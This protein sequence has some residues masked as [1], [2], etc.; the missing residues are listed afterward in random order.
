MR[1][2]RV[3]LR[4]HPFFEG[5]R[6]VALRQQNQSY[7]TWSFE[8]GVLLQSPK[9]GTRHSH[10]ENGAM[11]IRMWRSCIVLFVLLLALSPALS[12]PRDD[13][14]IVPGERIG[15]WTL[16]APIDDLIR[17]NGPPTYVAGRYEVR[18]VFSYLFESADWAD[19]FTLYWWLPLKFYAVTFGGRKTK[20]VGVFDFGSVGYQTTKK[21][22]FMA[23]QEKVV[24]AYGPPAFM[25]KPRAGQTRLVY[26]HIGIAFFFGVG[27]L[28][29]IGIFQPGTAASLWLP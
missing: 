26:E 28:V 8:T 3:P 13:K 6:P 15:K 29:G 16:A 22:R 10:A 4:S 14:L 17:T 1:P 2:L 7:E 9:T 23:S 20:Y 5:G 24:N 25:T 21:I 18:N 12:Q 19:N 11:V 27:G